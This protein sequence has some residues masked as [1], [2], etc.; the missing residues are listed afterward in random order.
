MNRRIVL[1]SMLVLMISLFSVG[2]YSFFSD[3]ENAGD[4]IFTTGTNE[5]LIAENIVTDTGDRSTDD[6]MESDFKNWKPGE[7]NS[8]SVGWTFTNS[9]DQD[10]NYKVELSGKWA[11]GL[12]NKVNWIQTS[13]IEWLQ[14]EDGPMIYKY[15]NSVSPG[16]EIKLSFDVWCESI[17]GVEDTDYA[18][19]L[20][21]ESSQIH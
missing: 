6:D 7:D 12:E 8:I 2:T 18:I 15:P 14:D 10:S 4:I 5:V 19:S 11:N 16:D 20:V 21:I 1:I 13:E 17:I 9:G 3:G